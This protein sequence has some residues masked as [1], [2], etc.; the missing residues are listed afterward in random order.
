MQNFYKFLQSC[1][2]ILICTVK[3]SEGRNNY[4]LLG[5]SFVDNIL[6]YTHDALPPLL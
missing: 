2:D 5:F 4:V 1:D 6:S 3:H